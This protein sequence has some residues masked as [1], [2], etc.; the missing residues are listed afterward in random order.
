[1]LLCCYY[2]ATIVSWAPITSEVIVDIYTIKDSAN[3]HGLL[4][5]AIA[6]S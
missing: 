4:Y 6:S 5:K 2:E 1:M 3:H